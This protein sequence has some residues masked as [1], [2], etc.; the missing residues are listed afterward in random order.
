M[1]LPISLHIC[2]SVHSFIHSTM[3]FFIFS[4]YL[5]IH[6]LIYLNIDSLIGVV[7]FLVDLPDY[8]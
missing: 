7:V 3:S 1:P 4:S 5:L 6:V 8:F 2:F